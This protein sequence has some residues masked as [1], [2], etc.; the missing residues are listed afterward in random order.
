MTIIKWTLSFHPKVTD[1]IFLLDKVISHQ[2][3]KLIGRAKKNSSPITEGGYGKPLS[4]KLSGC[5]KIKLKKVGIRVGYKIERTEK[6]MKVIIIGARSD[7]E[8]YKETAIRLNDL[9]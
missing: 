3:R 2:V 8:V 6:E 9:R 5:L 7:A 1:D 4:G